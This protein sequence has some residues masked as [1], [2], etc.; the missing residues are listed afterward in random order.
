MKTIIVPIVAV[1]YV[2]LQV[3]HIDV[4]IPQDDAVNAVALI[5]TLGGILYNHFKK[6][7]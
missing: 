7:V 6:K 3:F 2:G 4:D 1:I 5:V